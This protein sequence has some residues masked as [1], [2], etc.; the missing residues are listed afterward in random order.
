MM[1]RVAHGLN[2]SSNGGRSSHNS[3]RR[4]LIMSCDRVQIRELIQAAVTGIPAGVL[5]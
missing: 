2:G 4:V 5:L 3:D 1:Q